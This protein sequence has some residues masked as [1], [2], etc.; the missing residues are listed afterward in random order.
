MNEWMYF[1]IG[2]LVDWGGGWL[3][4]WMDLDGMDGFGWDEWMGG[5]IWMDEGN[6]G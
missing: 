3:F 5:W 6:D 1:L 4:G 2:W